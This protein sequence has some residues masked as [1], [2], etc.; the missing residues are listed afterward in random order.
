M[1]KASKLSIDV[2]AKG[3]G[4]ETQVFEVGG[5]DSEKFGTPAKK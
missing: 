4:P 2:V 5:Y 1:Q 3:H